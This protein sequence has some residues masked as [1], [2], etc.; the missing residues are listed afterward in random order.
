VQSIFIAVLLQVTQSNVTWPV[1]DPPSALNDVPEKAAI[2]IKA[3][4]S[5]QRQYLFLYCHIIGLNAFVLI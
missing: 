5:F 4:G 2:A 3:F 1:F